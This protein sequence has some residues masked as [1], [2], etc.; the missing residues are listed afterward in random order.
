MFTIPPVPGSLPPLTLAELSNSRVLLFR[1][2]EPQVTLSQ[3]LRTPIARP[4]RELKAEFQVISLFMP[5][6]SSD[7]IQLYTFMSHR[8][9]PDERPVS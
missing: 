5:P 2:I 4:D 7:N 9:L 1:L 6:F 3:G 8:V